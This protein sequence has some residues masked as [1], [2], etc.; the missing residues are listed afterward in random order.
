MKKIEMKDIY[1]AAGFLEGEGCF[2]AYG[3]GKSS[4]RGLI[5]ATSQT[6]E[7]Q[8]IYRLQELFGGITRHV[9]PKLPSKSKPYLA[10]RAQGQE[11]AGLMMTIYSLMSPRRKQQIKEAL[12]KWK[13][14]IPIKT[15]C[16]RGHP[17]DEEN[18]R[19]CAIS[20][21]R[22][23]IWRKCRACRRAYEA[24]RQTNEVA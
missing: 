17:F 10:W 21:S 7:H 19:Y 1:W 11:A 14:P 22:P 6:H 3:R 8:P 5:V 20:A 18:T 13:A 4:G 24:N 2:G 23:K 9:T 12:D 16:K 15:H